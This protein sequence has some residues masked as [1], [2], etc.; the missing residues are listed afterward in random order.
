MN[1]VEDIP[2]SMNFA[3]IQFIENLHEHECVKD[4]CEMRSR[5]SPQSTTTTTVNVQK[6]ITSKHQSEE[7]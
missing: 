4:H 3:S 2:F 6:S 5:D 1:S 7:N